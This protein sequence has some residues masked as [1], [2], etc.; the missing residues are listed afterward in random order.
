MWFHAREQGSPTKIVD[1]T[2]VETTMTYSWNLRQ[3]KEIENFKFT[4]VCQTVKW[5]RG[6]M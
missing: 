1:C 6:I 5:F 4:H 2:H 3:G